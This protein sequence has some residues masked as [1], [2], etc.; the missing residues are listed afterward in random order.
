M[1]DYQLCY[2]HAL[3]T[4]A[5]QRRYAEKV[6]QAGGLVVD[7]SVQALNDLEQARRLLLALNIPLDAPSERRL[8]ALVGE[9]VNHRDHVA[10]PTAEDAQLEREEQE[11]LGRVRETA[12][13]VI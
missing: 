4:E 7:T 6:S 5:R 1:S 3:E 10:G 12:A 2:W 8:A 13:G 11:V 9:R